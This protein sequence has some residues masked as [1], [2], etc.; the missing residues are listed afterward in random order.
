MKSATCLLA[1]LTGMA[2]AEPTGDPFSA[3]QWEQPFEV[4][5]AG[6]VKL[7]LP[8]AALDRA[9][10]SLADLRVLSPARVE[11][12]YLLD[13]VPPAPPVRAEARNFMVRLAEAGEPG[14]PLTRVLFDAGTDQ[15]VAALTLH[16]P[17]REFLKPVT[18]EATTDGATW[19][20]LTDRELVFRQPDGAERLTLALE[21]AVW[22]RFRLTLSDARGA[23][24]PVSGVTLTLAAPRERPA[25]VPH[26]LTARSEQG[27]WQLDCGA[28][29]LH[30]DRIRLAVADGVFSRRFTVSLPAGE[31]LARGMVYRVAADGA[32]T[33]EQV[34]I[35]LGRRIPGSRLVLTID[36]GDSP[37]LSIS[38]VTAERIPTVL[39]FHAP[40]PGTWLLLS[41]NSR[42]NPPN[43]DL[44]PLRGMLAKAA[45]Q[46]LSPGA[47]HQRGTY[48]PPPALPGIDP[49]GAEFDAAGWTRRARV[50]ISAPGV[51]AIELQPAQ[52]AEARDD[53][54][55]LRLVQ[56]GRQVPWLLD[57]RR[58]T[59]QA[60]CQLAPAPPE[61]RP[62]PT[63]SRWLVSRPV[64][65][66]PAVELVLESSTPVFQRMLRAECQDR[67]KS[68]A[69]AAGP[70]AVAGWSRA[71]PADR[72]P[73][74]LPLGGE[75]WPAEFILET[76]NGDN[77][78]LALTAAQVTYQAP[79]LVAK[80]VATE[81][82][83]L[84]YGNPDATPPAYDLGLVRSE[85]LAAEKSAT[86]ATDDEPVHPGR[87]RPAGGATG[88]VWLWAALG[89]V[90]AVLLVIVARL[91][92]KPAAP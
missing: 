17:A 46:R 18:V 69:S 71:D 33:A 6:W 35:P 72:A 15:P 24:V 36:D 59:R 57:A 9:A 39:E 8:P 2:A 32:A 21:P 75:R 53:L 51:A 42:A 74:H 19:R 26:E 83:F 63:V 43:Y 13:N 30:L 84:Y 50:E 44:T 67:E 4:A 28:A 7:D 22:R 76:D 38:G 45:G 70:R 11:T 40:G 1:A 61:P 5:A 78:P 16:S 27:A 31:T 92:P 58:I 77:P 73:F 10:P 20:T 23:P 56:N 82:L 65:G 68:R 29:N 90:V 34:E 12:P 62:R 66:Y 80:L 14:G 79:V 89:L 64:G 41:G 86:T 25:T 49:T 60:P 55:D 88:S 81:P 85:L 48:Q 3:W 91:L 37:P 87:K 47:P 54:G 52:L